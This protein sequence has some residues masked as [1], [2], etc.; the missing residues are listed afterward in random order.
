[1]ARGGKGGGGKRV[2]PKT[3]GKL[4]VKVGKGLFSDPDV[5]G[6]AAAVPGAVRGLIRGA[7][8]TRFPAG[9]LPGSQLTESPIRLMNRGAAAQAQ[10]PYFDGYDKVRPSE[11]GDRA[12]VTAVTP[13]DQER[14]S[15]GIAASTPAIQLRDKDGHPVAGA[16]V[17]FVIIR[18]NG[19]VENHQTM[20][21][22]QGRAN[23]GRWE[24]NKV[25]THILQAYAGPFQVTFRA[26][27]K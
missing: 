10:A 17:R 8:F 19:D 25:G 3:L 14:V 26:T 22:A 2:D 20:T 21:N 1:M 27:V 13:T 4:V 18:G 24:L 5:Q 6:V 11:V 7:L 23:A 9:P 12:Q 15:T 16:P